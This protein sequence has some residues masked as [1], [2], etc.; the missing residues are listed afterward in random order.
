[1]ATT[2][3][4]WHWYSHAASNTDH[5]LVFQL[6]YGIQLVVVVVLKWAYKDRCPRVL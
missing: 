5:S 6:Y 2:N 1:M 3:E 4:G